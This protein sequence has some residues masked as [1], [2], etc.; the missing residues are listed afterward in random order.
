MTRLHLTLACGDYDRTAPLATGQVQPEGI[1][2]N[3]I[4][5]PVEE[6]F[7]RNATYQD[8]AVAEMS[9]S[10]YT[11]MME[12]GNEYVAIPVFP[13]RSFRHNGVYVNAQAGIEKPA[14]LVG[15][16][17]GA[18]E[19]QLTAV[20][21]IRGILAEHYGV[22]ADSVSYRTGGLY[23]PGRVEKITVAPDGVDIRAIP[24]DRTLDDMLVSG[25]IDALYTPRVPPSYTHGDGA[26]RRL[27]ED[28]EAE[29][30]GYFERTGIFPI[31]HVIAIRRDVYEANRWIA[32]SLFKAFTK[33]KQI[34]VDRSEETAALASML[35]W[36][37]L[38]AR[39][40]RET[41]GSDYWQYGLTNGSRENLET[42]LRYS[43]EQGLVTRR[44]APEEMFA[45]ET[46]SSFVI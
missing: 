29:E 43:G 37:Y 12:R 33:A 1:D 41:L 20:V 10:S 14:D 18:P 13:S 19:M 6:I 23:A 9:L 2:L 15:R 16:V 46:L 8:F 17:V 24:T 38:A 11:L 42:F 27:W 7:Y 32:Q 5:L 4:N 3:V 44:W 26:V 28:C 31:M 22:P 25:E 45:P 40:T 35:P 36:S 21:W 30:R 34:V 39:R